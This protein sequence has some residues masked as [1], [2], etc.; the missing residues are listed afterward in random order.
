MR[1]CCKLTDFTRQMHGRGT[2]FYK[3]ERIQFQLSWDLALIVV[4]QS[5]F[6]ILVLD[7]AELHEL[8]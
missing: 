2:S 5:C 7:L 1:S 4:I 8:D 3:Q 6:D